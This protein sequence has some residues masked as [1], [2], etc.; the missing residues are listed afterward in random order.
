MKAVLS[1]IR[2]KIGTLTL[3]FRVLGIFLSNARLGT[4]TS[5]AR[6]MWNFEFQVFILIYFYFHR[7]SG[8]KCFKTAYDKIPSAKIPWQQP[9]T[10]I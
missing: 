4:D 7:Y 9:Q 3:F 10:C 6:A 8:T 5:Y 1:L 2:K